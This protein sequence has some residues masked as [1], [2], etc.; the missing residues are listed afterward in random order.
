M[1]S[2]AIK[3]NRLITDR[4]AKNKLKVVKSEIYDFKFI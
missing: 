3:G 1:S 2:L 4:Q